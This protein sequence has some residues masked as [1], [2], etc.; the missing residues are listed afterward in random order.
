MY[1]PFKIIKEL[2]VK[3]QIAN[4]KIELDASDTQN[5]QIF[6]IDEGKAISVNLLLTDEY[7]RKLEEQKVENISIYYNTQLMKILKRNYPDR[8]PTEET[9]TLN[10]IED[11]FKQFDYAN[12][13]SS[14]QGK[15]FKKR[16]LRILQDVIRTDTRI[17]RIVA[18]YNELLDPS[19]MDKIKALFSGSIN[20][21]YI[22]SERGILMILDNAAYQQ[23]PQLVRLQF[24]VRKI[25]NDVQYK[26]IKSVDVK[27]GFK[28][29][30]EPSDLISKKLII[31]VGKTPSLLFLFKEIK[32]FD[33]F[34]KIIW[35][36]NDHLKSN[37]DNIFDSIIKKLNQ[38]Y[39]SEMATFSAPREDK[40]SLSQI[41]IQ[42]YR[43]MLA[44]FGRQF[45]LKTYI[46]LAYEILEK[47]KSVDM[48]QPKTHLT[49]ILL[50][51]RYSPEKIF[52]QLINI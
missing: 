46:N 3:E 30:F 10:Q 19:L 29:Y 20:I 33:P 21:N 2:W 41:E 38:N 43:K 13:M 7:L 14:F 23:D 40:T 44:E 49:N 35:L 16:Y 50:D 27:N 37:P 8:Y 26:N 32:I 22:Q 28:E 6:R 45:N 31:L 9:G 1:I 34:S 11:L 15:I 5:A 18:M 47:S 52:L 17:K 25:F 4:L 42:K 12:E 24:M 48:F 51:Q 36:T 39:A